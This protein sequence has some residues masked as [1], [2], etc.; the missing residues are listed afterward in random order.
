MVNTA[1]ARNAY[2]QTKITTTYNPVELVVML[3]DGAIDFL[4]KAATAIN[5]REVPIKIKY[6]DKAIAIIEEL[7][8]ALN[9][10]VGGEIALNLQNLYLYMMKELVLANIKNDANKIKY[11]IRLLKEI[12]G[13][14]VQIKDTKVER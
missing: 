7:L 9:L 14:W 2:T 1:Y 5:M 11:I 3:Y 13:A 8:N 6:I 12:R 4:D 10:E